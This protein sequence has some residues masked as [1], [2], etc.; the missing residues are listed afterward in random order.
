MGFYH[1]VLLLV[2]VLLANTDPATAFRHSQ[3]TT[4]DTPSRELENDTPNKRLLRAYTTDEDDGEERG[5]SAKIPGLEKIANALKSSKTKELEALL[6]ADESMIDTFKKLKLNT[7]S[8]GTDGFVES[9]KVV[10]L[11]SS[12][13]FKIWSKYA[14]Q[15]KPEDPQGAMV[16]TL[17]TLF[18][19]KN[20]ATMILLGKDSRSSR[21][22]AKQLETAQFN[23]W[24]K[25]GKRPDG[26]L[27]NMFGVTLSKIHGSSRAKYVWINYSNYVT[28]R[29]KNH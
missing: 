17:T 18:G 22:I 29:V 14:T 7:V 26:V 4:P 1:V 2:T 6:K 25:Q 28:N 5:F 12:Q 3:L 19:D 20:L 23:S 9:K 21:S 11:F 15:T 27:E 13:N 10:E 24:Y 16:A 8:V